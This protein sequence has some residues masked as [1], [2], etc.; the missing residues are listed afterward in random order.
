[1]DNFEISVAVLSPN[2][3]T[4]HA[5]TYTYTLPF[6]GDKLTDDDSSQVLNGHLISTHAGLQYEHFLVPCKLAPCQE[7]L[8]LNKIIE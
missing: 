4:R 2:I 1:M 5:I 3:T 8:V 7:Y 6:T